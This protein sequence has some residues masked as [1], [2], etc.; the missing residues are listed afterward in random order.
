MMR[1]V[2]SKLFLALISLA[3]LVVTPAFAS[4]PT[5]PDRSPTSQPLEKVTLQL[6][7]LHQF[8]FAGYYA[9]QQKGFYADEGLEVDIRPRDLMKN[10]I[11]QVIEGE[12]E[13]GVADTVLLLYQARNE[14]VV[15]VAPIFQHSPNVL[16]TLESSDIYSAYDLQDKEV[17]FYQKD[18]DGFPLLAMFENIHISPKLKRIAAKTEPEMLVRGEVDA[19][20]CYIS[21][22]PYTLQQQG[23]KT[24]IIQPMNYG[25]DFYGDMLFTSRQEA[26]QHPD[27]VER[28]KRATLKGWKYALSHKVEIAK[29][30]QREL[31]SAK[32]LE[33]LLYEAD[34][35]E[36]LIAPK[37]IPIGSMD[38]GRF[39]FMSELFVKHGLIDKPFSLNKGIYRSNSDQIIF[40][41]KEARWIKQHPVVRVAIDTSWEP[42]EYVNDKG[43]LSGIAKGYLDFLSQA[44]GIHFQPATELGWSE[45][46]QRAQKRELDMFSA[47][48]STQ[49]RRRYMNYTDPYLK[50]PMVIATRRQEPFIS[51]MDQLNGHTVSVVANYA[52][53]EKMQKYYPEIPLY[54]V[55]T[56]QE[57]LEAVSNGK[58][59]AYI[60]N[61]AVISHIINQENLSNM[62]ISGE[63]P[64]R[65]DIAMA[66]RKDWPELHSII[67]K[68]LNSMSE[69]TQNRLTN[70]WLQVTYK[71]ELQWRTLAYIMTPVLAILFIILIY[72]RRLRQLNND[73]VTTQG[74]LTKTNQKLE[75]L[76]ITDP[77]TGAFNRGHTDQVL[78]QESERASR[79]HLN[80]SLI[81]IDLDNFKQVNDKYGHLTG[82]AVLIQTSKWIESVIRSTDTFGRWGGEEFVIIC[83]E[84]DLAQAVMLAE[85]IRSGIEQQRFPEKLKQTLSIGVAQYR[86]NESTDQWIY[87]TDQSLYTAKHN[88]KNQVVN[89]KQLTLEEVMKAPS[90]H[91]DTV[92]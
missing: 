73:L 90:T 10:N 30:I 92:Q 26:E 6:K 81:L 34:A 44:T 87:R 72:N 2:H 51:D 48:I 91:M 59:Y 65:A 80:L 35:I 79:Y 33:H 19:Y 8:Q 89:C 62:Q 43:Q 37:T 58:A 17:A 74:E 85:K 46:V 13:Y 32:T 49:E 86:F 23:I 42:I 52:S 57:G 5:E 21:N 66:I 53:H 7:W 36:E 55:N 22:E 28:F 82:D 71:K 50:F 68:V 12:A 83:P 4:Q 61:L 45:A 3:L 67:Q 29:Y 76:S 16:M 60:D 64:F 1:S 78:K 9:A 84:T 39:K 27:R 38:E 18:T 25:I 69:Q 56:P 63:T 11:L 20:A 14:P 47:V 70:P 31:G 41:A 15:I 24:R 54:L 40:S 75:T 88:G 77:L